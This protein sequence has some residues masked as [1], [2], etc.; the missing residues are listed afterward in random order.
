M[1][2]VAKAGEGGGHDAGARSLGASP[3]SAVSC[4]CDEDGWS[5]LLVLVLVRAALHS[6]TEAECDCLLRCA[7]LLTTEEAAVV[8]LPLE[9]L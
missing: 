2:R 7:Q 3:V 9:L 6:E 5:E 8:A 1:V 4:C